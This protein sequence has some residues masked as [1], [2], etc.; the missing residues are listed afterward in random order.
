MRPPLKTL[1]AGVLAAI[2]TVAMWTAPSVTSA[3]GAR[4]GAPSVAS[5]REPLNSGS[6][7]LQMLGHILIVNIGATVFGGL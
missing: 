4:F 7:A 3:G 6:G 2:G 1:N 5:V